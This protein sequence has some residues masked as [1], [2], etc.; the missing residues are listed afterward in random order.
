[1]I[2]CDISKILEQ[3]RHNFEDLLN[4]CD[5][6]AE[7]LETFWRHL[8]TSSDPFFTNFDPGAQC[9]RFCVVVDNLEEES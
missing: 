9:V 2:A 6:I 8:L 5:I 3:T 7:I 1:M 4:K